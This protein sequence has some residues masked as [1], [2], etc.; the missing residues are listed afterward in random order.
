MTMFGGIIAVSLTGWGALIAFQH[1]RTKQDAIDVFNARSEI[2]PEIAAMGQD[3][4][5]RAYI[6]TKNPR[7]AIY[8]FLATI[9]ALITLPFIFELATRLFNMIWN[10]SGR[11]A[12]L[13]EGFA[14]WLFAISVMMILG[15]IAIGGVYAHFYHRNRPQSLDVEL[16]K[17][18]EL[19]S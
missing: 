3:A 13:D 16:R 9:T 12:D 8:A 15:L 18:M 10:I 5:Q 17:E 19:Q 2:E 14:P 6:R 11:P 4:F 1:I 7:P